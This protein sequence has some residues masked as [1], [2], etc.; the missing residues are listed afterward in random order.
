MNQSSPVSDGGRGLQFEVSGDILSTTAE[1]IRE[2]L[3]RKLDEAGGA[4]VAVFELGLKSTRMVDSVGLN[5]M[6]WLIK[7]VGSRGG[8]LR[9]HVSDPN[10]LRTIQ[11][12]RLD[13]HAEVIH[14]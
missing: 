8:K 7:Q 5:L 11:F 3:A 9:I 12:T 10:V 14:P 4:S 1:G 13:R 2:Q 6:V